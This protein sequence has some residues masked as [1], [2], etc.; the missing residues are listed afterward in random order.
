MYQQN[1]LISLME[2]TVNQMF[3]PREFLMKV[4]YQF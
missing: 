4:S 1:T 2:N 3:R